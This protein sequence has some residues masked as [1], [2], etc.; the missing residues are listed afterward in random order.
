MRIVAVVLAAGEGRRVGGPKA[1]LRIRG[2]TFLARTVSA[3][4]RPGI[5]GVLAVLG[6]DARRVAGE[7]G[8]PSTV[9]IVVNER[10]REGMLSSILAGLGAAERMKADAIMIHAVDHPFVESETVD[11]V[12][13][14]LTAGARVAVPVFEGQRGHPAGFA[15]PAW[16]ALRLAPRDR[17]ARAVLAAH[18]DWVAHVPSGPGCVEQVNTLEDLERLADRL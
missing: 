15:H 5:A 2:E 12:A 16:E 13:A 11:A 10:W 7:A 18:P 8:L 3:L 14:A 17:G 6:C 4:T 1:L 9:E